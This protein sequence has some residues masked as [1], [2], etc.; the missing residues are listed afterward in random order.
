MKRPSFVELSHFL[1]KISDQFPKEKLFENGRATKPH[2][3]A[4]YLKQ[5]VV[6]YG[7]APACR[8]HLADMDAKHKLE[9]RLK[10]RR[11]KFNQGYG[12]RDQDP[13]VEVYV[14]YFNWSTHGTP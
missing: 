9:K 14:A 7:R 6:S 5:N 11:Y 8:I 10:R 1:V 12:E 4:N 2:Q 3:L 13:T